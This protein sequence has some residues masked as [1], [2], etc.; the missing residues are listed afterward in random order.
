MVNLPVFFCKYH[1][2]K[3]MLIFYKVGYYAHSHK[4]KK[5][6]KGEA[7]NN[8]MSLMTNQF[9]LPHHKQSQGDG[10]ASSSINF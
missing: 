10:S 8:C 5:I 6:N 2:L 3:K 7:K 9:L 4:A 1:T